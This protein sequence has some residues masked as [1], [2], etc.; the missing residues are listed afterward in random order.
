M[1][2]DGYEL[3]R[4]LYESFAILARLDY[5][6]SFA[7]LFVC[8]LGWYILYQMYRLRFLRLMIAGDLLYIASFLFENR[9]IFLGASEEARSLETDLLIKIVSVTISLAGTI[10]T[11]MGACMGVRLLQKMWAEKEKNMATSGRDNA[12]AASKPEKPGE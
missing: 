5:L 10:F 3:Y 9:H 1:V 2:Q 6:L 8:L 7:V 12:V 4:N 11:T